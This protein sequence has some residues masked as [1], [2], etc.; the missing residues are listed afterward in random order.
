[1]EIIRVIM[2]LI[3]IITKYQ[4]GR[5]LLRKANV[6]YVVRDM[7]TGEEL[8][9]HPDSLELNKLIPEDLFNVIDDIVTNLM[10]DEL[11]PAKKDEPTVEEITENTPANVGSE[12]SDDSD[13]EM[14]ELELRVCFRTKK[15]LHLYNNTMHYN[16]PLTLEELV[17]KMKNDNSSNKDNTSDQNVVGSPRT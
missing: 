7:H 16:N 10:A 17:K 2:D 6:Y 13:D 12:E 11:H 4:N 14:P 1:M 5:E 15:Q 9:Y 8:H 3:L